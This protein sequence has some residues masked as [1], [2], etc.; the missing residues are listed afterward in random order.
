MQQQ[1]S[2]FG[3]GGRARANKSRRH[4]LAL[5]S[6]DYRV[7]NRA[8][9]I[10]IAQLKCIDWLLLLCS[11]GELINWYLTSNTANPQPQF[12]KLGYRW[13]LYI[14]LLTNQCNFP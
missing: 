11:I 9:F 2:L 7:Q 3:V 13:Q 1:W 14:A 6:R 10:F 4:Y 5:F 8:K 12:I